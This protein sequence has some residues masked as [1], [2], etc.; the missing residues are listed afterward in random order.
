MTDEQHPQSLMNVLRDTFDVPRDDEP[1]DPI[2]FLTVVDTATIWARA[3][4][5]VETALALTREQLTDRRAERERLR[6]EIRDLVAEEQLLTRMWRI[7]ESRQQTVDA[8]PEE[9]P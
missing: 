7:A 1:D 2:A 3:T 5:A 4:A 8:T 6:V 9:T